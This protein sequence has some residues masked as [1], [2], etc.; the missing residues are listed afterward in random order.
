MGLEQRSGG[1]LIYWMRSRTPRWAALAALSAALVS[2]FEWAGVPAALLLGP[3]FAAITFAVGGSGLV[4]PGLPFVLCQ[5]VI[6]TMIARSLPPGVFGELGRD[7]PVFLAGIS[8]VLLVSSGLAWI[9]AARQVLPG[10][11]AIWGSWPGAASTMTLLAAEFGA[12]L[13]LVAVMQYMRV[14]VVAL[15]A[16]FAS[17]IWAGPHAP[18]SASQT[19][20]FDTWL[21]CSTLAIAWGGALAGHRLRIPGGALLLPLALGTLL[22]DG[23]GIAVELP[24]WLLG[25]SY[26]GLGWRIGLGFDRGTLVYA[27]RALP[28][29]LASILALVLCCAAIGAVL[30][31]AT[32]VDP[33]TAYLATSPGGVDTIAAVAISLPVNLP[34]IMAMQTGRFLAILAFGPKLAQLIARHVAKSKPS[35]FGSSTKDFE[36]G[37]IEDKRPLSLARSYPD[38]SDN[39]VASAKPSKKGADGCESKVARFSKTGFCQYFAYRLDAPNAEQRAESAE[40]PLGNEA[41]PVSD[42]E[43]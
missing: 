31:A 5:G 23:V 17:M 18:I 7:W 12:D 43:R 26:A 32:G 33:L 42:G 13:R 6:G 20:H 10:T 9:L 36:V 34:M 1:R 27:L 24:T 30:V 21:V 37:L 14:V 28:K 35:G 22:Q 8:S 4:L 29:M 38:R 19:N 40:R 11:A 2:A 16:S 25:V 41:S 39:D 15:A 3:L